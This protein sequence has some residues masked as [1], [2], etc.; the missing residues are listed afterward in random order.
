[1]FRRGGHRRDIDFGKPK[2]SN[3]IVGPVRTPELIGDAAA[4]DDWKTIVVLRD[5]RDVL[6]SLYSSWRSRMPC[7]PS[8]A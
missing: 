8:H 1:M 5:P 7:R 4:F 3:V 2:P 6:V